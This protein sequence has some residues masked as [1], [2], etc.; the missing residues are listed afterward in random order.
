MT[1][2]P[3]QIEA[4]ARRAS[5]I[6]KIRKLKA[7]TESRGASEQEAS[8]AA[9]MMARLMA[10][11]QVEQSELTIKEDSNHC[12]MDEYM[13]MGGHHMM[14]AWCMIEIG[15][16]FKCKG[17]YTQTE[18]DVLDMGFKQPVTIFRF[19]GFPQ[20]VEAAKV[21][22]GIIHAGV[23]FETSAWMKAKKTKSQT[24]KYQHIDAFHAGM[25][26]RLSERLRV[27]IPISKGTGLIVLKDQLVNDK[28]AQYCRE[29]NLRLGTA[30]QGS[31]PNPT[32][33]AKGQ[34]AGARVNINQTSV[35][36]P[37]IGAGA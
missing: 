31:A 17:W 15:Q 20:D 35:S 18:D 9:Q 4:E 1:K 3:E 34:A 37:L 33:Y 16:I 8:F 30:R 5:I 11:F 7:M 25:S 28:F 21:L 36:R 23:V 24:K 32:E 12:I 29:Q 14:W 10:E 19:Y 13:D 27:L 22:L 6:S 26:C 2:T